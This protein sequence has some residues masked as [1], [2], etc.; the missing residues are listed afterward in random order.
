MPTWVSL[1]VIGLLSFA[2]FTILIR[3]KR[4]EYLAKLERQKNM[5]LAVVSHQMR[6]PVTTIQWYVEML[7]QGDFGKLLPKQQGVLQKIDRAT[8]HLVQLAGRFLETSRIEHT[9]LRLVPMNVDLHEQVLHV[10]D[11]LKDR[12]EEK[13]QM[14]QVESPTEKLLVHVDPLLLYAILAIILSNAI[15][16]TPPKGQIRVGLKREGGTALL[17]VMD[18]GPGIPKEHRELLF[19][20]AFRREKAK[21]LF[22]A[23]G[24]IGLYLAQ[25][26]LEGVGGKIWFHTEDGKGTTFYVMLPKGH[27]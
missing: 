8:A 5:L 22:T 9:G 26:L 6:A 20:R 17:S 2:F 16:Y 7:Q 11:S 18:T 12:I 14:L 21:L 24:G 25:Q 4:W 27:G 23:G 19:T 13:Q 3:E 10:V 15:A 1:L